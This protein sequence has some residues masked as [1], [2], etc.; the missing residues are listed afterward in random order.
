MLV[1]VV[2]LPMVV[3]VGV[4]VTMVVLVV[5][6]V[7][8]GVALSLRGRVVHGH[9]FGGAART[10]AGHESR[11]HLTARWVGRAYRAR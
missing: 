7:L 5:M 1:L 11:V 6:L 2:E 4:G 10:I 8:V 3:A 9:L